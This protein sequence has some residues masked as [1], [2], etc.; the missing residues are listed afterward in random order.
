MDAG[1]RLDDTTLGAALRAAT[2]HE[3]EREAMVFRQHGVRWSYRELDAEVGETARALLALG[4]EPGDHVAVWATNRPPWPL[5]LLAAARVGA[6]LVAVNPAYRTHE[7]R[8]ALRQSDARA[9]FVADRFKGSDYL[10]MVQEVCPRLGEIRGG[11]PR[12]DDLPELRWVVSMTEEAPPGILS[13]S[14][15]RRRSAVVGPPEFAR[16]EARVEPESPVNLQYTSGTTG[17]PKG[18]LLSHASLLRNAWHVGACQRFTPE[19]RVCVPVPFYHCFG[20]VIGI[21]GCLVHRATMLVPSEHFDARAVLE[22]VEEERATALYGVPTMFVAELEDDSF[23]GRDLSSLR[24]GV[25]AGSPCPVEVMK[26]VMG[27]M[28]AEEITIAY[29][30]T[31]ASPVITQTLTDDPLERRVETVGRPI[32]G[33]EV[34]IVD[35]ASG[36]VLGDGEPGELQSR[37]HNTMLGYYR[38]PEATGEAIVEGG[39]LRTGD[40]A[41]RDPDGYYR[42]TGRMKDMIIRGGENIYPR[43]IEE[44]LYTHPDVETAQVVGVPDPRFGE[45][46]CAWIRPRKGRAPTA[47]E[48]RAFCRE[49]LAYFKVPRWVIFA[50]EFPLTVTGKVQKYR[51]RE[52]ARERLGLEDAYAEE[53]RTGA[54]GAEAEPAGAEAG[55]QIGGGSRPPGGSGGAASEGAEGG[56]GGRGGPRA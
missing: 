26:R 44:F 23:P 21:L 18:V 6:V 22:C 46:V 10:A 13:W 41:V 55:A 20:S 50:D 28:G 54:V 24:T 56:D 7:L 32:P 25:M 5:L 2:V 37:G 52:M 29:G 12:A 34:R 33:V 49:R 36:S 11:L 51:L 40:L 53:D 16:R 31:E 4:I 8:Y 9:L 15:F 3:P 14:D 1:P 30:L 27:E 47:D 17:F 38:M 48:I 45:E 42:I 43:E 39:W 19:D 35:P